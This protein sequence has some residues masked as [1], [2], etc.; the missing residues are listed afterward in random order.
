MTAVCSICGG[1]AAARNGQA[2]SG[3]DLTIFRCESCRFDFLDHDP[4][5]G[6]AANK[7]DE[8]RLKAA[9][10]DIPSVER[11]FANGLAQSRPY[12]AEYIGSADAGGNILEIGCSWGYFLA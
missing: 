12:V 5:D 3:K 6:L 2:R 10:L 7:L 1:P 9:G 4:T 8:T 11:D